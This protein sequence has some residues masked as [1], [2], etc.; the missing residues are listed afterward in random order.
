ME[1]VLKAKRYTVFEISIW[2]ITPNKQHLSRKGSCVSFKFLHNAKSLQWNPVKTE[3]HTDSEINTAELY[4]QGM[5]VFTC[6]ANDMTC[7]IHAYRYF[8]SRP[9]FVTC[10]FLRMHGRIDEVCL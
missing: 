4:K 5:A 1:E 3:L 9:I 2:Q 7:R 10:L 6:K 8:C